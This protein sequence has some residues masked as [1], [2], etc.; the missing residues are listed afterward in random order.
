MRFG[1]SALPKT[2]MLKNRIAARGV[3]DRR[4]ELVV[5][6]AAQEVVRHG[7]NRLAPER[8]RVEHVYGRLAGQLGEDRTLAQLWAGA[9]RGDDRKRKVPEPVLQV[10]DEPER[11]VVGQVSVVEQQ[12][13]RP[14]G[15]D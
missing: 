7:G 8:R 14:V 9:R 10:G 4:Y 5:T 3:G 13:E 11:R 6:L 2:S 15:G 12:D 1:F